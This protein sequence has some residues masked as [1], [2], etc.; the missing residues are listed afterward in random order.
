MGLSARMP[1]RL[2]LPA[3]LLLLAVA[4]GAQAAS[5]NARKEREGTPAA[6]V[7]INLCGEPADI[8]GR[9]RLA[10][11]G[12]PREVWYFDTPSLTLFDHGAVVRLRVDLAT[13]EGG[14]ELTLKAANQDCARIDPALVPPRE[15]KCEYDVHGDSVKGAVSLSQR[16]GRG[17]VLALLAGQVS[18]ADVLSPAQARLLTD[19]MGVRSVPRDVVRLGPANLAS[20]RAPGKRYTVD[21]WQLPRDKRY[22]EISQKTGRGE[23]ADVQ[24][25]LEKRLRNAGVTACADQS[26]QAESKLRWLAP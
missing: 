14:G 3:T 24:R 19:G 11:D 4:G 9:L 1:P 7:Q 10:P 16:L 23:A 6:E 12:R 2:L 20:Y 15:G 26:S 22:V 25:Q 18:L 5:G 21:V 13:G 8:V 17:T